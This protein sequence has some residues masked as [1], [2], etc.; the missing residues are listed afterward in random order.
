M[1]FGGRRLFSRQN[2][3]NKSKMETYKPLL[4]IEI[5][6]FLQIRDACPW[7]ALQTASQGISVRLDDVKL[8]E[9]EEKE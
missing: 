4:E 1:A 5:A 8:V 7:L 6:G 9:T 2:G 3:K